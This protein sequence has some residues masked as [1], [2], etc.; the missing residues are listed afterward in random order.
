M[1]GILCEKMINVASFI[2][3]SKYSNTAQIQ[4]NCHIPAENDSV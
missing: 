4:M 2:L 1:E 3:T